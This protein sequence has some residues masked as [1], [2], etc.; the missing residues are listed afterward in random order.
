[1]LNRV[2]WWWYNQRIEFTLA[3]WTGCVVA[4]LVIIIVWKGWF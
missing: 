2:R 1:M 4:G 3:I